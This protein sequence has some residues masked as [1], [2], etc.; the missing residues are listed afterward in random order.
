LLASDDP[1][2]SWFLQ[3]SSRD[4]DDTPADY[5]LEGMI[6]KIQHSFP[7]HSIRSVKSVLILER[8]CVSSRDLC[9]VG[10]EFLVN[11]NRCKMVAD[12]NDI[13][14]LLIPGPTLRKQ[15]DNFGEW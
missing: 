11:S 9:W 10:R 15:L 7:E 5:L 8:L 4:L 1:R 14:A 13:C 3:K 6:L 2:A 12:S